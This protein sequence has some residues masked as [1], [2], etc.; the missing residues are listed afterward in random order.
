MVCGGYD[1][2]RIFVHHDARQRRTTNIICSD[3]PTSTSSSSSS[4]PEPFRPVQPW[5]ERNARQMVLATP[6][7]EYQRFSM[8]A[9]LSFNLPTGLAQSAYRERI[10]EAFVK[11]F[12]PQ[13]DLRST[14]SEGKEIVGMIPQLTATDEALR[15]TV[16]ALGTVGLSKTTNDP[17]LARQGRSLY[18]KAL[19]ETKKALQHPIRARSTAILPIPHVSY[20]AFLPAC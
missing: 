13:G 6:V 19:V 10:M 18:G 3:S 16:L 4:S 8:P 15:L 12:V 9:G 17:D 14:N 7:P 5:A 1:T 2:D 20:P 11:M